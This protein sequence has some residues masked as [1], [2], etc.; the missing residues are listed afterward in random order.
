MENYGKEQS[1]PALSHNGKEV[2][3][4]MHRQSKYVKCFFA[5]FFNTRPPPLSS[6][7]LDI[8]NHECPQNLL[9]TD[10]DVLEP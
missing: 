3:K 4:D 5:D 9:C 2:Q 10:Q 8:D 7:E 6:T 1:I